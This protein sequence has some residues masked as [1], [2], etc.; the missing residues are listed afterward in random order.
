MT[1]AEAR[2]ILGVSVGAGMEEVQHAYKKR[3]QFMHPD[4]FA[5]RPDG[6]IR[7]ATAEFQRLTNARDLLREVLSGAFGTCRDEEPQ[8][9]EHNKSTEDPEEPL[10][11]SISVVIPYS[12]AVVGNVIVVHTPA[13]E[14]VRIRLPHL[15]QVG[16]TVRVRGRGDGFTSSGARNDLLVFIQ[17]APEENTR[18]DMKSS[19][20]QKAH[21]NEANRQA[22]TDE[23][24]K[25]RSGLSGK[26]SL[27][28]AALI[29]ITT[30]L[31][32]SF[33]SGMP[34]SSESIEADNGSSI[35]FASETDADPICPSD[36]TECWSWTITPAQSCSY[37]T[38]AVDLSYSET[39]IGSRR[40]QVFVEGLV[41]GREKEIFLNASGVEQ[42]YAAISSF[43][44]EG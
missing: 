17:L 10:A 38:V 43:T 31:I 9:G 3:S 41:A 30:I 24:G 22:R 13:G 44:C 37:A 11:T 21:D 14:A 33:L 1:P 26:A 20:P 25:T 36:M 7:F 6:E 28:I 2:G 32:G 34:S 35:D 39:G 27:G 40:A 18:P 42:S 12:Q 15:G 29:V 16:T 19:G 4:R 8:D 5:G 23:N